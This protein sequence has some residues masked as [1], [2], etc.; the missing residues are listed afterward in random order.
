MAS[1]ESPRLADTN[2][3]GVAR[4]TLDD[5]DVARRKITTPCLVGGAYCGIK[6]VLG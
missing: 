5:A 2:V 3:I 6:I 4:G 1:R